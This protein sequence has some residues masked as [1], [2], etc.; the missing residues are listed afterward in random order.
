MKKSYAIE[1]LFVEWRVGFEEI[2]PHTF[3]VTDGGRGWYNI[4]VSQKDDVVVV[5]LPVMQVPGDASKKTLLMEEVLKLN[6]NGLLF[7]AY[8]FLEGNL[9]LIDTLLSDTMDPEELQSSMDSLSLALVEHFPI[10]SK[11]KNA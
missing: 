7:G 4:V 11:Y 2:G 9:L 5:R 6:A 1:D 8:A 10:L 3:S